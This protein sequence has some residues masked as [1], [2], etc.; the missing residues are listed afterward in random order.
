MELCGRPVFVLEFLPNMNTMGLMGN[1]GG[2]GAVAGLYFFNAKQLQQGGRCGPSLL[3][4]FSKFLYGA[5]LDLR[6][7][8]I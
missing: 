4:E 6:A 5:L 8:I 2:A 7:G 3:S 1:F